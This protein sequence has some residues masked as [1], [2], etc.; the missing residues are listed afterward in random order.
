MKLTFSVIPRKWRASI[1]IYSFDSIECKWNFT[2][3]FRP[4]WSW[5][6]PASTQRRRGNYSNETNR[7]NLFPDTRFTNI[8]K[9]RV[10]V[11]KSTKFSGA[12]WKMNPSP[13][14]II[15]GIY[16]REICQR[17]SF[18]KFWLILG[19]CASR[20]SQYETAANRAT[21]QTRGT[22]IKR[23]KFDLDSS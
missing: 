22:D 3:N 5:M 19:D 7:A 6:N 11:G 9:R 14:G 17:R 18:R 2:I 8:I 4:T 1:Q 21:W 16:R 13:E 12:Q 10:K 23:F 15:N 20:V